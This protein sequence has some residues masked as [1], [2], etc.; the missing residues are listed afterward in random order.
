MNA[1]RLHVALQGLAHAQNAH[2]NA[3]VYAHERLQSRA[4]V[5]EGAAPADPI[6]LH[7]AMRRVLH[8][9][10]GVRIG[11]DELDPLE[12][13][14]DH[15]VDGVAAGAAHTEHGDARLKLFTLVRHRQIECHWFRLSVFLC[16]VY[17]HPQ[18]CPQP[19]S[20]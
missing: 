10:L 15:V 9:G 7:P 8:Q 13:R 17:P 20:P 2:R 19:R 18:A 14:G 3:L 16:R 12:M 5:R 1:A 6:V 4:P 11:H